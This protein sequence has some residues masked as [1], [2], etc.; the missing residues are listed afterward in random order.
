[1]ACVE[2]V[3]IIHIIYRRRYVLHVDL[4]EP[5]KEGLITGQKPKNIKAITVNITIPATKR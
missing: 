4:E 2:D 5:L 3:A 1:M